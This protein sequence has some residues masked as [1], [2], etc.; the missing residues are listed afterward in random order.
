[1]ALYLE[2]GQVKRS[3]LFRAGRRRALNSCVLEMGWEEALHFVKH[4]LRGTTLII[5]VQTMCYPC[6]LYSVC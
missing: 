1:M 6:V 3:D 5:G 4:P 2:V